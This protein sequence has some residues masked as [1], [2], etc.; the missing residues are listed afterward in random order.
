MRT[1]LKLERLASN[2]KLRFDV[3]PEIENNTIRIDAGG[4]SI[5]ELRQLQRYIAKQKA[6]MEIEKSI[7]FKISL[8]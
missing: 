8:L 5:D 6:E 4:L 1:H 2:I 7:T 3:E